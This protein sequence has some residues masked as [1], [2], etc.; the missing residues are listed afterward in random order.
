MSTLVAQ[1]PSPSARRIEELGR[2]IM[3]Y[4][5]I[6]EKLQLSH[7]RLEQTV[8]ALHDELGEKNRQLERKNRLAALGEMAAGMAHEIRNPLGAI[9]LYASLLASDL[10]HRPESLKLVQKI[11]GGVR[12]LE[13]L[14]TQVL[15]FTRE[16]TA[17]FVEK[18]LAELVDEVIGLAADKTGGRNVQIAVHGPRPFVVVVDPLLLGQAILNLVR[19]G[20]EASGGAGPLRVEYGPPGAGVD[21]RQFYLTV[22]DEGAGIPPE[23][24]DRIFNPFFTTRPTGTGLGLAVVHR[25]VEAHD[26]SVSASN[27]QPHG[28]KFEIR[29]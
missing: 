29:I 17:E 26:G 11:A 22:E 16:M 4:S 21:C 5:E 27:R 1:P 8:Q 13:N 9:Q 20:I 6:T 23:I 12:R 19:N 2:I 3:A 25:V 10:H 18:D 7:E 14:V 28:A 15:A 24:I